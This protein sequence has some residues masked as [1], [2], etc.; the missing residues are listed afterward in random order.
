[1]DRPPRARAP[2]LLQGLVLLL[3]LAYLGARFPGRFA[4]LD[5]LSNFPAHF[6]VAFLACAALLAWRGSRSFA[7]AAAT[8]AVLP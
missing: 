7:L 8:A 6:A 1:M 5:N 4:L 3:G 2:R